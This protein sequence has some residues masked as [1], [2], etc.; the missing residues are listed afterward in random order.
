VKRLTCLLLAA[1]LLS[2]CESSPSD[3]LL[4]PSAAS[5]VLGV[6]SFDD[7][8]SQTW[9]MLMHNR[10]PLSEDLVREVALNSPQQWLP[11]EPTGSRGV[12]LIHGLGDSPFSF[13]DIAPQ[14]AKQGYL[15]R[16]VLL[17]GHGTR[18]ADLLEVEANQWQQVV[19]EQLRL[20]KQQVDHVYL[21]GFSTGGNLALTAAYKDPQVRGL[22]LFSPGFKASTSL[23][24][25]TPYI[26]WLR[27]WLDDDEGEEL[28]NNLVRYSNAPTNAFAQYHTTSSDSLAAL[29][30]QPFNRPVFIALSEH[31]SVLDSQGIRQLFQRRFS[32]PDSRLMWFGHQPDQQSGRIIERNSQL[33]NWRISN[34]SHMGL[35][36]R[37]SNPYYGPEGEQRICENGQPESQLKQCLSNQPVWYSAYGLVEP[38]KYHARLTFNPYF[39]EMMSELSKVFQGRDG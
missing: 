11:S 38:G 18:P 19:A 15:V 9:Q 33:P 16:T 37:P 30:K 24:G 23:V 3:P 10:H 25:L 32:H 7:Y 36:F 6:Q 14:L 1:L 27:P 34:M 29:D 12:L 17:P 21:G 31:D 8:Q 20:L 26:S 5:P 13:S 2:G 39:D 4:T 22:M 28:Q 35:L